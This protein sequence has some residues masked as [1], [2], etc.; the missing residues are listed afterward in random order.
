MKLKKNPKTKGDGYVLTYSESELKH[1]DYLIDK[2][3]VVGEI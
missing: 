3:I 2:M 1:K